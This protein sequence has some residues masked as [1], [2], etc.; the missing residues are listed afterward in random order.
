MSKKNTT[1]STK[2]NRDVSLALRKRAQAIIDGPYDVDTRESIR[3]MLQKKDADLADMVA[4]AEQ[5]ETI[6]DTTRLPS[7]FKRAAKQVVALFDRGNYVPKFVVDAVMDAL[8]RAAALKE[9]T[10]K[11]ETGDL[12]AK[13]LAGLFEIAGFIKTPRE[14][15]KER[16]AQAL[17]EIFHN[18][19]TPT[20]LWEAVGDFVCEA[21][22]ETNHI[23]QYREPFL[24]D[25]ISVLDDPMER[26]LA[27]IAAERAAKEATSETN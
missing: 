15:S 9:I 26:R 7:A 6:L 23:L 2:T 10:I 16:V 12:D 11:G 25:L 18:P 20:Q 19:Q 3:F 17:D 5:G 1:R 14:G 4:R 21:Q 8:N 24:T 22:N 13:R 27:K